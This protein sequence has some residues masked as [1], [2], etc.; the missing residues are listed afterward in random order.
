M[1]DFPNYKFS[2]KDMRRVN[3]Y[4]LNIRLWNN[5]SYIHVSIWG[6]NSLSIFHLMHLAIWESAMMHYAPSV[7]SERLKNVTFIK[8]KFIIAWFYEW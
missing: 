3:F 4:S 5:D 1:Y 2:N 8:Y 7:V 6:F